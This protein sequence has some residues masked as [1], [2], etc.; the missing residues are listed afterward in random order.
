M[1]GRQPQIFSI[2]ERQTEQNSLHW[3][4]ALGLFGHAHQPQKSFQ[5]QTKKAVPCPPPSQTTTSRFQ[6]LPPN[7]KTPTSR[8]SNSVMLSHDHDP[9]ITSYS[10]ATGSVSRLGIPRDPAPF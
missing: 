10:Y 4:S 5:T 3:A 1:E 9:C 6:H 8:I 7:F 2:P